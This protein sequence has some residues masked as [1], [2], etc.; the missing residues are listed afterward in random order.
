[1]FADFGL[2][3]ILYRFYIFVLLVT[4]LY[5]ISLGSFPPLSYFFLLFCLFRLQSSTIL[6]EIT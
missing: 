5:L 2:E 1:M 4:F 6:G 3:L